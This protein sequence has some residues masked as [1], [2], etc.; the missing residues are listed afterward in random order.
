[1][2][3]HAGQTARSRVSPS[4]GTRY[5]TSAPQLR[6]CLMGVRNGTGTREVCQPLRATTRLGRLRVLLDQ[7]LRRVEQL[8]AVEAALVHVLD[9]FD[10]DLARAAAELLR[11]RGADGEDRVAVIDRGLAARGVT[12]L[13]HLAEPARR[14]HAG[15]RVDDLLE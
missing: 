10:L 12:G 2:V 15:V 7:R 9:P 13:L 3:S 8:A 14:G 1:M 4:S 11:F 6:Q 5:T